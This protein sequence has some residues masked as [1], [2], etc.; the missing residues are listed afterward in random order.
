MRED[1]PSSTAIWVAALRADHQRFDEPKVLVDPVVGRLL[2]PSD[3]A[4]PDR[5]RRRRNG[6]VTRAMRAWMVARSRFAEDELA[7]ARDRGTRQY[8][9]LGA[10]LDTFAYRQPP[11]DRPLEVF[12]VDHPATQLWKRR[13]LAA[14]GVR[15]PP[16]VRY[17]PS[18]F[19][20]GRLGEELANAG[21]DRRSPAFFTWLGVTVYLTS[22]AIASTLEFL[23]STAPGGGVVLDYFTRPTARTPL[24]SLARRAIARRVAS[25]GEPFRSSFEEGELPEAL[26]GAGFHAI[27]ELGREGVNDRYFRGRSDGL[28]VLGRGGRLLRA[29]R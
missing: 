14:A 19:E 13:R 4:G 7:R 11:D 10:G 25:A 28:R 12:E 23:G 27:V 22:D 9:L 17:V 8:A 18:D 15:I 21:F 26:R 6:P 5:A 24:E 2:P 16:N 1:A 29:E 20:R 3:G